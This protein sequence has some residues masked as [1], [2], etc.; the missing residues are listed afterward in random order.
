MKCGNGSGPTPPFL[1]YWQ[2]AVCP[3]HD[4]D[5]QVDQTDRSKRRKLMAPEATIVTSPSP[6]ASRWR[7]RSTCSFQTT[8][9]I[10][11]ATYWFLRKGPQG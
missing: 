5:N 1:F 9:L 6:V 2:G 8:T 3:R 11:D 10:Y 7:L 4:Q